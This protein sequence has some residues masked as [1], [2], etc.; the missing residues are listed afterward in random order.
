[1]EEDVA[2]AVADEE[3]AAAA[4]AAEE[5]AAV[6][7]AKEELVAEDGAVVEEWCHDE[8]QERANIFAVSEREWVDR[9]WK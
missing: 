9:D 4:A 6:T 1:M 2:G 8:G 3:A 7:S 5:E